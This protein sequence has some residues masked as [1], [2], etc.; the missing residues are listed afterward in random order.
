[1]QANTIRDQFLRFF[2][3]KQ[4]LIV[5]SASLMPSSPNLLF[6]NAGMNPFVPCFLEERDP[7]A[8]RV[9]NTQKCI[10][11]GGKHNDLEDVGFDTYHHT[12]FEMLG[13][14]S[15]G[16]YFKQEAID[17]AWEFLKS[18]L[19][20]PKNRLYATIYHPGPTDPAS[21]DEEAYGIW[22]KLFEAEGMDPSVHILRCGAK[23]N[24]WMMGDTGPCGPCTEI[25]MDLTPQGDTRGSLVNKDSPWC[26][27][28][29]NLVF[30]QFN[31]TQD[32]RFVPLP[33][34][35]V[36][37]G[38]GFERI[39]GICAQ[40]QNF[41]DFSKV[42][43]NYASDLFSAIFKELEAL[44]GHRYAAT[45]PQNRDALTDSEMKDC[46]FRVIADHLRA[47]SFSIADGI[48][49]S[50]EGRGYVL[51][52][53]LRRGVLFGQKL[54]IQGVF[55]PKLLPALVR[56]MGQAFPELVEQQSLV[57]RVLQAEEESFHKT[58][59]RGLQ[60]FEG[61]VEQHPDKIPGEALF[62]LYDT[63]GFPV[64]LTGL[65]ARQRG[66]ALDHAGFEVAMQSQRERARA[67]Q[68]RTIIE[69]QDS[70]HK[71]AATRFVGYEA[72]NLKNYSTRLLEQINSDTAHF[73]VTE[74]TP[75]YAE[76]GGQLGDH[77]WLSKAGV[78]ATVRVLDTQKDSRGVYLHRIEGPL[79]RE[80]V[81]APVELSVDLDR[82]QQISQHHSATHVM[83]WALRQALGTHVHQA[84][85]S[86]GPD[87]LRFDYS[88]FEAPSR[89]T[90][91]ALERAVNTKI[92]QNELVRSYEVPFAQKP[93]E[94]MA[95]FG[96]KY[97]DLVRVVDIGGYS[98]ELCGGTH[99]AATGELGL[100]LIESE[101][102]IA[103]GTR[104]LEARTALSSYERASVLEAIVH[105][106][107]QRFSC[108]AEEVLKRLDQM[109]EHNKV[110]SK[111]LQSFEQ[112]YI[113]EEAKR[114]ASLATTR[115]GLPWL[116]AQTSVQDPGA[117]RVLAAQVLGS[118]G[119]GA[120]LLAAPVGPE[121][122]SVVTL[123]SPEAAVLL[124]SARELLQAFL[125]PL[126]GKGGGKADF[127]MGACAMPADLGEY[128][129]DL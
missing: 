33:S 90:L 123:C 109:M 18:V 42:A 34:Q 21:S 129:R 24:F 79:P 80:W 124:G 6:N 51:R 5:P 118:L 126:G 60:L 119:S 2:E 15:F 12:F 70:A 66:V 98:L 47:L 31:A 112:Q 75:F 68:S 114:L 121:K 73:F 43:S 67:A 107:S 76:M 8:P 40:T 77:G 39:A 71:D 83:H 74:E 69:V 57:S 91:K 63:Y 96:E 53:I 14:W 52:R 29:W 35:H 106:L 101:T 26:I 110:L 103:S 23:E 28:L 25:H 13:N 99:V 9:A 116:V 94:A 115:R 59:E 38:M 72:K 78:N 100:F 93:K 65:L 92:L 117:L 64:D 108:K 20:F 56:T 87:G 50:N 19:K 104:R 102:A 4:H 128:L 44:S 32:G 22:K 48:L 46:A 17:W 88:H 125:T 85:S 82:R 7:P 41:T 127:A 61:L 58:L 3:S 36:D 111:E 105:D 84:G 54:G 16:D 55:L 86:V 97:G 120:V 89:D 45:L 49:P 62:T 11:A 30:I 27:E 10:R 95:F 37:T 81:G 122:L 1:M 113:A